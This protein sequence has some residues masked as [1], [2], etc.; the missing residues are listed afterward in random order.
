MP[1]NYLNKLLRQI[2]NIIYGFYLEF[3]EFLIYLHFLLNHCYRMNLQ[4]VIS[5][6]SVT[7][8]IVFTMCC[9]TKSSG[10]DTL[11]AFEK[12]SDR[13][14]ASRIGAPDLS[15]YTSFSKMIGIDKLRVA[16]YA[17]RARGR[18]VWGA[19]GIVPYDTLWQVGANNATLISC[20]SEFYLESTKFP[21]G[22][23]SLF[24]IPNENMFTI[25]LNS[26]TD[27][28][29][30]TNYLSAK[31]VGR[32]IIKPVPIQH[33]VE[34]LTISVQNTTFQTASLLISWGNIQLPI[35]FH[36]DNNDRI[37]ST[38][39]QELKAYENKPNCWDL[40]LEAVEYC[41]ASS[42]NFEIG[43]E[44]ANKAIGLQENYSTLLAKAR[45]LAI[46]KKYS[47][48]IVWLDKAS[49]WLAKQ[50]LSGKDNGELS[51]LKS[52]WED[53]RK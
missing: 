47:E 13:N 32:I 48:A 22:V 40:Y 1:N 37:I 8:V 51:K 28:W 31:D 38:L 9:F 27:L 14:L 33:Q 10:Q 23:Y 36:I 44:W 53:L 52:N 45:L 26:D 3:L 50:G 4:Q 30:T 34:E 7:L 5:K 15:P 19:G 43:L 25:I 2:K 6:I 16:Y 35:K 17:P 24:I 11:V 46:N 18:K 21:A 29:G 12:G 42:K 39:S 41:I 49:N 20:T